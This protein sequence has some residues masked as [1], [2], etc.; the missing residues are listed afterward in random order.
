MRNEAGEAS[1][2]DPKSFQVTCQQNCAYMP[3][4]DCVQLSCGLFSPQNGRVVSKNG[5]ALDE[6]AASLHLTNGDEV[7][8]ECNVGHK[9]AVSDWG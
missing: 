3:S 8:I 6:S 1:H 2:A 4:F 7:S 9:K 5:Q